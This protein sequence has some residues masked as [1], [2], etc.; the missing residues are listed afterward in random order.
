LEVDLE[1]YKNVSINWEME[2]AQANRGFYSMSGLHNLVMSYSQQDEYCFHTKSKIVKID[3]GEINEIFETVNFLAT[4]SV[5]KNGNLYVCSHSYSRLGRNDNRSTLLMINPEGKVV[6]EYLLDDS[7]AINPVFYQDSVLVYDF[8]GSEQRGHLYRINEDG[9]LIWK[10]SFEG[11]AGSEPLILKRGGQDSILLHAFDNYFILDMNGDI[12]QNKKIGHA[13][14]NGLYAN[15]GGGIYA[16]INPNLLYLT[17]NLDIIWA[18]KPDI[19]FVA[20]PSQ[21]SL[22][23]LYCML[24]G[25]RMVSLDSQGKERWIAEVT[26]DFG[27]RPIILANGE[28]LVITTQKSGKKAPQIESNTYLETFFVDGTKLLKHELPGYVINTTQDTDGTIFLNTGCRRV[29]PRK[30]QV[31]NSIKVF[32]IK[33]S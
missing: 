24:T 6:W 22:G 29:F 8:N 19:G 33:I 32:S 12:L 7:C 27:Y 18:Y 30:H 5:D 13:N 23:N 26:G 11:N 21:D 9:T 16:C 28:I 25:S 10:K 17:T 15:K 3:D 31:R 14:I 2:I 20:Y 4:P 1:T